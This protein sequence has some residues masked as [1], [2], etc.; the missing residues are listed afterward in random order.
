[1]RFKLR[2]YL[3][4]SKLRNEY[5]SSV[6]QIQKN[7]RSHLVS[8]NY[9][10]ISKKIKNMYTLYVE[11]FSHCKSNIE[12][13]IYPQPHN[14]YYTKLYQMHFCPLRKLYAFDIPRNAFQR[15]PSILN[16]TNNKI[17]RFNFKINGNIFI[18]PCYQLVNIDN[19]YINQI[20]FTEIDEKIQNNKKAFQTHF[21]RKKITCEYKFIHNINK[22]KYSDNLYKNLSFDSEDEDEYNGLKIQTTGINDD[23]KSKMSTD[24]SDIG[25]EKHEIKRY[26]KR[27]VTDSM[28]MNSN[29]TI[30]SILKGTRRMSSTLSCSEG[31]SKQRKV[32]FGIV[33]FSY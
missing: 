25:I 26:R 31:I 6:I 7:Y 8:L 14:L 3:L 27:F 17:L 13:I 16:N 10:N 33:Q 24:Y 28:V 18:D 12:I 5:L 29:I 9:K 23:T 32:S 11:L 20:D 30:K 1:M 4:I 22:Q 15:C 19:H 2:E 21:L